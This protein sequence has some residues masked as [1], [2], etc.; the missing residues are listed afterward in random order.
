MAPAR[1]APLLFLAAAVVVA[2]CLLP[3]AAAIKVKIA[4]QH[5]ECFKETLAAGQDL[6]GTPR[7]SM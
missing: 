2:A 3:H 7:R 5:E 4:G 1:Q 6:T